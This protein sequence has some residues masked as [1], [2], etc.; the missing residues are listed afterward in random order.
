LGYNTSVAKENKRTIQEQKKT[1]NE[2][3]IQELGNPLAHKPSSYGSRALD[4][5]LNNKSSNRW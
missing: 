4:K 2:N 3:K 5:Q 1:Y